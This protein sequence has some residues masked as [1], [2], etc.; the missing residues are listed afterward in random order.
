MA[1]V[2]YGPVL[3]EQVWDGQQA[4]RLVCLE[5]REEPLVSQRPLYLTGATGAG[6]GCVVLSS[7]ESSNATGGGGGA[8]RCRW[9]R[10]LQAGGALSSEQLGEATP[11]PLTPRGGRAEEL[12]TQPFLLHG[13]MMKNSCLRPAGGQL[14]RRG[15]HQSAPSVCNLALC[16]G[17]KRRRRR[18]G[19]TLISHCL[20]GLWKRTLI[21]SV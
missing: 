13:Q 12:E 10:L 2:D 15:F 1:Q 6:S 4:L 9:N 3:P 11:L 19:Q 7:I 8:A 14:Y 21:S 20:S 18:K 16:N 17:K 5:K